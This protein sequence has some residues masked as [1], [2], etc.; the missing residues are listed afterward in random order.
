MFVDAEYLYV[1]DGSNGTLTK[2]QGFMDPIDGQYLTL[3]TPAISTE[4]GEQ[5]LY[6]GSK[7]SS[8]RAG[9]VYKVRA[10]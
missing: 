4:N 3:T 6:F 7:P 1:I 9:S 10:P 2:V 5:F 8:N